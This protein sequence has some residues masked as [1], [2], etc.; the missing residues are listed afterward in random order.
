MIDFS[1]VCLGIMAAAG[2]ATNSDDQSIHWPHLRFVLSA[3]PCCVAL[4]ADV[5]NSNVL[6]PAT[7]GSA[8]HER[9]TTLPPLF[10][11]DFATD[12]IGLFVTLILLAAVFVAAK[13][14]RR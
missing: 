6:P 11:S 2:I 7:N 1:P 14:Q 5:N 13:L 4:Q 3:E 9:N 10:A 8:Q 12:T